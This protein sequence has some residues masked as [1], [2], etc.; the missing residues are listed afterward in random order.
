MS[1]DHA[2]E[3]WS[4]VAGIV[5]TVIAALVF[6]RSLFR[7]TSKSGLGTVQRAGQNSTQISNNSGTVI[8]SQPHDSYQSQTL[9]EHLGNHD[10]MLI[11]LDDPNVQIEAYERLDDDPTAAA[12][13][14]LLDK[15][16]GTQF[17]E[18]ELYRNIE[19]LPK[20]ER[21][22]KTIIFIDVDDLTVINKRFGT[23]A[24]DRVLNVFA[25]LLKAQQTVTSCGRCGDDT[26]FA[27]LSKSDEKKASRVSEH[28]RKR[29][30][31]FLWWKVCA[32]MRVRCT[33]GF[34]VLNSNEDPHEWMARA[35]EGMLE[36]KRRGGN[37]VMH[38]PLLAG[39][40]AQTKVSLPK[41]K[42][43]AEEWL[44]RKKQW[45]EQ[46]FKQREARRFAS[47]SGRFSLRDYFS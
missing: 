41:V 23:E 45:R 9:T 35:I 24:G 47:G 2:L 10:N 5:G 29:V 11:T 28:I 43:S 26:F 32:D 20:K 30:Q 8:I 31:D 42:M 18:A 7:R 14:K 36:G 21:L 33:C 40:S 34:S 44:E 38:G 1:S 39:A 17:V 16:R 37:V 4:Y 3:W 46:R 13:P 27:Y 6:V 15:D 25:N 19:R 22:H 12:D